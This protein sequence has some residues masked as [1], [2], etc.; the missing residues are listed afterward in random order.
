MLL[1]I[2]QNTS[3]N[4]EKEPLLRLNGFSALKAG[5][6][7]QIFTADICGEKKRI[8]YARRGAEV[9]DGPRLR[10]L[11]Y[12]FSQRLAARP[13]RKL[14]AFRTASKALKLKQR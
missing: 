9:Y 7:G 4:N 1:L 5:T 2:N 14:V 6:G 12:F 10:R 13:R 11:R 3:T 8:G